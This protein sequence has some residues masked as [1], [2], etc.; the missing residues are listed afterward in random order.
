MAAERL[1]WPVNIPNSFGG[2]SAV[3]GDR[4]GTTNFKGVSWN[5]LKNKWVA[6]IMIDGKT[7]HLGYF[8]DE[9]TAARAY[10]EQAA[11]LGIRRL[12]TLCELYLTKVQ[13]R[14]RRS[15]HPHV[16]PESSIPPHS[17]LMS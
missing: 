12:V 7:T 17:L 4:G 13:C 9:E 2:S 11:R 5:K 1:G 6:A 14:P 15:L 10:D 3:K 8:D 16:A